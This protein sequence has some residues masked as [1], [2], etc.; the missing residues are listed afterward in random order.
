M[1]KHTWHP[2]F[3]SQLP[4][5]EAE[6]DATFEFDLQGFHA[7]RGITIVPLGHGEYTGDI[8]KGNRVTGTYKMDPKRGI[9]I[10]SYL[11]INELGQCKRYGRNGHVACQKIEQAVQ[12]WLSQKHDSFFL[13]AA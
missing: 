8:L 1:A 7:K 11:R 6:P 13:A 4:K 5:S 2:V 12:E 3:F 10:K 9:R